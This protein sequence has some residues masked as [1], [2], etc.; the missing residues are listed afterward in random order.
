MTTFAPSKHD[1]YEEDISTIKQEKE[2]QTRV[3]GANGYSK[4]SRCY[5]G[6]QEE[7]AQETDRFR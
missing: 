7:R 4:W 1:S 3:Q 2:E 6:S 5:R